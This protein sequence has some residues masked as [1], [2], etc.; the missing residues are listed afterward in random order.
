MKEATRIAIAAV[1]NA[2][3]DITEDERKAFAAILEKGIAMDERWISSKDACEILGG[4][5]KNTLWSYVQRGRLHPVRQS[6]RRYLF[7][8][9]EVKAF[10][11]KGI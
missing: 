7:A 5:C 10:A 9:S 3:S 2:D 6:A 1:V 8:L 11:S 4:I